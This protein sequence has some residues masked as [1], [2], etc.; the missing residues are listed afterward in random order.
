M[1][2][3]AIF[4]KGRPLR[5]PNGTA[6]KIYIAASAKW[7]M[8]QCNFANVLSPLNHDSD[9]DVCGCA[10][11][12]I[13]SAEHL[14]LCAQGVRKQ[15]MTWLSYNFKVPKLGPPPPPTTATTN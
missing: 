3:V 14:A 2:N 10:C 1:G 15:L 4:T 13:M 11:L 12:S 7:E 8:S 5:R 6:R 9:L